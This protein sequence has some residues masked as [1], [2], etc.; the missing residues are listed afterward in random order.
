MEMIQPFMWGSNGEKLS[1]EQIA[2]RRKI[3]ESLLAKGSDTSPVGHWT[4]GAA[5]IVDA[6]SGVIQ[7]RRTDA[8]ERAGNQT[9][10]DDFAAL[11]GSLRASSGIASELAATSPDPAV[12]TQPVDMT[13]NDVFSGF[14]DTVKQGGVQNPYALAAIAA[15]GKAE[16]GFSPGNVNRTWSDPSES[17]QAGTAGGIM[18]W[19]GP[20]FQALASTGDLS[21]Q[22]QAKF[23]L[24]ENPQLIQA[25]N[26][27]QS[28]EEA[29]S[30][31]NNAWKFAGYDRPGGE[32]ARR[33]SLANS[34]LPTFQGQG[35]VAALTP[36]AAIEA[37]APASG[38]VDPS[39]GAAAPA[40]DEGRFGPNINLAE[41]PPSA[42]QLPASL[43][44]QGSAYV[45]PLPAPTAVEERRVSP[46]V[47]ALVAPQGASN[48]TTAPAGRQVAQALM[49][50]PSGRQG[51]MNSGYFPAAPNPV[52][53][54]GPS[55]QQI[56]QALGNPFMN[57]GQRAVAEVLLRQQVQGND[58]L[59]QL[60]IEKLQ[61]EV[62][63]GPNSDESFFGN[64]I[65]VQNPDGTVAY[66]QIGNKGSFRPIQLGEGQ[67]FAPP[68]KTIDTGTETILMDQ[69]GNVI[70]RTPKQNY[71]ESYEKAQGGVE[72]KSRGEATTGLPA[73]LMQADR[74]I[75]Q[76]DQLIEHPGL[77][78]VVGPLD[79]FRPTWA[80]GAQGN[81]ALARL[82]QLQGGAFLQ[83]F[84]MLKGG[85]QI[86]EVEGLKA[87]Q[88]QARMARA[89]SEAEFKAALRDFRDAVQQGAQKLREKAGTGA[90]IPQVS[91]AVPST[92]DDPLGLR[93]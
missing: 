59:R 58:P 68:T 49:G 65:A 7:Q 55:M 87:E 2:Q 75:Q 32:A 78:S 1:P 84:E 64:P 42:A 91:G 28:V 39:A 33:L 4:Q 21:P 82:T 38:T 27:A 66:G 44:E 35:Q 20:R 73:G 86:T 12:S 52:G 50:A 22:G 24:Q 90:S 77:A 8:A 51:A 80:L 62:A 57:P 5:R 89:Q 37:V 76:I 26:S 36:E 54:D 13:G 88:A 71:Q 70:S 79:Q 34:F 41:M 18:S 25:L 14:I 47:E 10:A 46:V 6:L 83:A 74:T 17:G 48:L 60:Q 85:G 53:Q 72:G 23:F 16:S 30:L 56:A 19:R 43:I 15:T 11:S 63:Q 31:M 61:R 92:Q 67:S 40:F 29:Q 9:A 69:A 3:A 45:P 93:N 81:D